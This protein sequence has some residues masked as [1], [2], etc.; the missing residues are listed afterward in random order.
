[1]GSLSG[2]HVNEMNFGSSYAP[3]RN[4]ETVA[5]CTA[6]GRATA[7]ALSPAAKCRIASLRWVSHF[8]LHRVVIHQKVPAFGPFCR[9]II[10][11]EFCDRPDNEKVG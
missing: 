3:A 1:M 11:P 7:R 2:H 10:Y 6:D 9:W 4:L 5:S 8:I